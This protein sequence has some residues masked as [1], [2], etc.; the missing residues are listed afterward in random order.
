MWNGKVVYA[1]HVSAA[2]SSATAGCGQPGR[3]VTFQVDGEQMANALPWNNRRFWQEALV[4]R[5]FA[6]FI[7]FVISR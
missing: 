2:G 4:S 5:D 3:W 1:I 6:T 7:P